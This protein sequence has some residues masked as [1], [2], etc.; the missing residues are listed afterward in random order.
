ML[1][2]CQN[3]LKKVCSFGTAKV[4]G[5][6]LLVEPFHIHPRVR[7]PCIM[8]WPKESKW[9]LTH[10]WMRIFVNKIFI[11]DGGSQQASAHLG[12]A[13]HHMGLIKYVKDKDYG[14]IK[15]RRIMRKRVPQIFF[16]LGDFYFS[17]AW[18]KKICMLLLSMGKGWSGNMVLHLVGVKSHGSLV[19]IL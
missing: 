17:Y 16:N 8:P 1:E 18:S 13:C 14:K 19:R 12:M 9:T 7:P 3:S 11:H 10:A 5:G 6:T 15:I 4:L 2:G